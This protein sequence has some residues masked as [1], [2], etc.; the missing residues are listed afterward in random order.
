MNRLDKQNIKNAVIYLV[1][2]YNRVLVNRRPQDNKWQFPGGGIDNTDKSIQDA[3]LR[4]LCEEVFSEKDYGTCNLNIIRY[5]T[6]QKLKYFDYPINKPT[7]RIFF[8]YAPDEIVN[9]I[10]D[11]D[12]KN[13][14]ANESNRRQW[15]HLL[16]LGSVTYPLRDV[17]VSSHNFILEN[18]I[19]EKF[20][21]KHKD[22]ELTDT[23]CAD[24]IK[25]MFLRY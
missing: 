6:N 17:A 15:I 11:T 25:N 21:H 22:E 2:K 7:T 9:Q 1:D 5:Y 18:K 3:S 23:K 10:K 20:I 19:I 16:S 8:G 24:V 13:V 4:E 14:K 12:L